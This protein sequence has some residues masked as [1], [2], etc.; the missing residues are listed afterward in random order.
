VSNCHRSIVCGVIVSFRY[1]VARM[2]DLVFC[3][4]LFGNKYYIVILVILYPFYVRYV[5]KL[6]S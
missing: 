6:N 3:M 4:T 2:F 1:S 5:W